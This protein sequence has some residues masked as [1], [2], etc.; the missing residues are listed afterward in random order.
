MDKSAIVLVPYKNPALLPK[1]KD[2]MEKYGTRKNNT[3]YF[4]MEHKITIFY[5]F[6]WCLGEKKQEQ[7]WK[8]E[9]TMLLNGLDIYFGKFF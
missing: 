1:Q 3:Y 5:L 2:F 9:H 8:Q 4:D 7:Y 6:V